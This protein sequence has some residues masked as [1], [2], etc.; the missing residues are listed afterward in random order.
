MSAYIPHICIICVVMA[1]GFWWEWRHSASP[2]A[3]AKAPLRPMCKCPNCAMWN[4]ADYDD[5]DGKCWVCGENIDKTIE[6]A[7]GRAR[8]PG[9]SDL[10]DIAG[11]QPKHWFCK[12]DVS[13]LK[14][15]K[16]GS[17]VEP[18]PTG[19]ATCKRC[20][21][22]TNPK[23]QACYP[24]AATS[25]PGRRLQDGEQLNA[26]NGDSGKVWWKGRELQGVVKVFC[27]GDIVSVHSLP[28]DADGLI[29]SYT[30][31]VN[32]Y[33]AHEVTYEPDKRQAPPKRSCGSLA[34]LPEPGDVTP[35]GMVNSVNLQCDS[36]GRAR[37]TVEYV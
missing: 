21:G 33:P 9:V 22:L 19:S 16:G 34:E 28:M 2:S 25:W 30:L 1:L 15:P 3:I 17:A 7:T 5:T 18:P 37:A 27:N 6:E 4:E 8:W 20:V 10:R 32:G 31:S 36:G 11:Y 24:K 12:C 29:A 35:L 13:S 14:P 23:C 26:N